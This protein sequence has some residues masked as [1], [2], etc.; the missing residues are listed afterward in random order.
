MWFCKETTVTV[1]A[2]KDNKRRCQRAKPTAAQQLDNIRALTWPHALTEHLSLTL[3]IPATNTAISLLTR[4]IHNAAA[5][6]P[7][8]AKETSKHS[9]IYGSHFPHQTFYLFQDRRTR[10]PLKPITTHK[11]HSP[12]LWKSC[13]LALDNVQLIRTS[14]WSVKIVAGW[15]PCMAITA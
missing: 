11:A 5:S 2:T 3:T 15:W 1:T 8:E 14:V 13:K 12:C 9:S 7:R 6:S 4:S 10:K